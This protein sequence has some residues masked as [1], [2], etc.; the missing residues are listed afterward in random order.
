MTIT[1]L[2]LFILGI[3]TMIVFLILMIKGDDIQQK[4]CERF[5]QEKLK[6]GWSEEMIDI[7]LLSNDFML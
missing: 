4:R 1:Y 7:V 6:E 2:L 5:R 3:F